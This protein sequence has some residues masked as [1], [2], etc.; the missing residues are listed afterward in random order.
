MCGVITIHWSCLFDKHANDNVGSISLSNLKADV[1]KNSVE[2]CEL[3][4]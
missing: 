4:L 1:H 2:G 3:L